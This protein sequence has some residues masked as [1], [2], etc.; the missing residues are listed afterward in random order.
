[1]CLRLLCSHRTGNRCVG[2]DELGTLFPID[3]VNLANVPNV[4]N[5]DHV[6]KVAKVSNVS[7]VP[8]TCILKKRHNYLNR[9]V[10]DIFYY[11]VC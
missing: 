10:F 7:N 9:K 2:A 5:V 8:W 3:A 11:P 6:S 4:E 1:M